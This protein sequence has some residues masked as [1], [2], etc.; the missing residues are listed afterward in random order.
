MYTVV[1]T[2]QLY[3]LMKRALNFGKISFRNYVLWRTLKV[4]GIHHCIHNWRTYKLLHWTAV[5]G[6]HRKTILVSNVFVV[7]AVTTANIYFWNEVPYTRV[8]QGTYSTES[9][10]L[11]RQRNVTMLSRSFLRCRYAWV[12]LSR[13]YL[14]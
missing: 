7:F 6:P 12:A 13:S 4:F 1:M 9:E 5:H 2:R 11:P 8:E 14:R 10:T 3:P